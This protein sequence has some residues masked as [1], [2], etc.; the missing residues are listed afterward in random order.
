MSPTTGCFDPDVL[1]ELF[2]NAACCAKKKVGFSRNDGCIMERFPGFP[3]MSC[4]WLVGTGAAAW[5]MPVGGSPWD[6]AAGFSPGF[7][8]RT[9]TLGHAGVR[10]NTLFTFFFLRPTTKSREI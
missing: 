4:C 5:L 10:S 8:S 2:T 9:S 3:P 7:S 6:M 1:R